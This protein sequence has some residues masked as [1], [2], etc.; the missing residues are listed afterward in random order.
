MGK[1]TDGRSQKST[2][3][4]S[5]KV[6]ISKPEARMKNKPSSKIEVS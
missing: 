4:S 3:R 2:S 1:E 5:T 6:A